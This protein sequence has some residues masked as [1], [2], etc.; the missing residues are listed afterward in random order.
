MKENFTQFAISFGIFCIALIGL[1]VCLLI[2]CGGKSEE[3]EK[4]SDVEK[5]KMED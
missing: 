5:L 4:S 1:V 3:S 2:D